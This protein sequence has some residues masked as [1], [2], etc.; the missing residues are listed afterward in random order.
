MP[1]VVGVIFIFTGLVDVDPL[2]FCVPSDTVYVHGPVPVKA[3][4][5]V[6]GWLKQMLLLPK[7]AMEAV[8]DAMTVTVV[9][10]LAVH[11]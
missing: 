8:G 2:T 4:V 1:A 3:N 6:A 11:P 5:T 7:F 9:L 10:P